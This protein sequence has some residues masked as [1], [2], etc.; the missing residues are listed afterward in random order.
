MEELVMMSVVVYPAINATHKAFATVH[1]TL[2]NHL[3]PDV[4]EVLACLDHETAGEV[5]RTFPKGTWRIGLLYRNG[6]EL[7]QEF[8][9]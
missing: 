2:S 8:H 4:L 1:C 7:V 9:P 3:D 6:N 5:V